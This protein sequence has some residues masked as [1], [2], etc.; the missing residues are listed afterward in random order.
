MCNAP[1]FVGL[2]IAQQ[3]VG[4]SAEAA[5]ARAKQAAADRNAEFAIQ[6][7]SNKTQA[8]FRKYQQQQ[9]AMALKKQD[10]QSDTAQAVATA[11]LAGI[12]SGVGGSVSVADSLNDYVAKG[13]R[14]GVVM[15]KQL[16]WA[17]ERMF[18]DVESFQS[19]MEQRI[20]SGTPT[21]QGTSDA[22]RW[23]QIG[24]SAMGFRSS[25]MAPG[26]DFWG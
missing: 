7:R 17:E 1:A 15:D 24:T 11:K 14:A 12:E 19:E 18:S 26:D 23:L 6:A 3:M 9:E 16:G 22:S 2:Q 4:A 10:L 20:V 13:A 21:H 25:T 5:A 8:A